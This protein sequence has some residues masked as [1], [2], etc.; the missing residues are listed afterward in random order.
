M[1]LRAAQL[2][3][4][5]LG[6][7]ISFEIKPGVRVTDHLKRVVHGNDDSVWVWTDNLAPADAFAN[8]NMWGSSGFNLPPETPITTGHTES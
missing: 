1:T 4:D 2:N 7:L 6:S 3:S 5:D 8:I